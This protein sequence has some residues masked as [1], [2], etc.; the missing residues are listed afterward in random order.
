MQYT[1]VERQMEYMRGARR[2]ED[3]KPSFAMPSVTN[4]GISKSTPFMKQ[5]AGVTTTRAHIHYV[6]TEH[7][8]VD[9][10]GKNL[11][12]RANALI[13]IAHPEHREALQK[14]A[15]ERFNG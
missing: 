11:Q 3:R 9:L 13:S 1:G 5:G 12:Q 6:A 2:S 4:K 10:Y 15:Y 8:V 14:M 7:G